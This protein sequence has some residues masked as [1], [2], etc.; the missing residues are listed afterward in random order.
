MLDSFGRKIN[1]LRISLTDRCNLRC[2]YC[3]PEE[4]VEKFCH[5]DILSLEEVYTIVEAFVDLGI[6]KLRFTGGEPLVR[7]GLV[8]LI[9][10]VSKLNKVKDMTMTTNGVLLKKYAKDLK[11]AGLNRVNISL[12]TL[13][14]DKYRKITR[15]GDINKVLEGIEEAKKVG[16]TPIKINSVLIGNFNEDEIEDLVNLTQNEKIDVRFIELMPI[17]EAATWAEEKFVPNSII[18]DRVKSLVPVPREDISSP[19]VY[20]KLP[21]GRGKVGIINPISCKFCQDCNRVRLTSTG[22]LKLCLHSNREIDLKEALTNKEDLKALILKSVFEKEEA[23]HLEDR[24][25]IDRN[26]NQIGG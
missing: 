14:P 3:M 10:R 21:Y 12:D 2:Q 5:D 11:E 13:N 17:G 25:Y 7:K 9:E 22:K 20:Y 15:G 8:S 26:M 24:D 23:H 19:A 16:L 1:Y 4:G 6:D 18:L